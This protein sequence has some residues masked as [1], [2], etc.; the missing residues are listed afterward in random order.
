MVSVIIPNYNHAIFLQ[1]RIESILHQTYQNFEIII[2]DDCSTDNSREVIE[3]FRSDPKVSHIVLNKENSGTTFK[4]WEKG[5][6]LAK[7][8]WIWIAESDD[9][10]ERTLLEELVSKSIKDSNIV[11]SY[12]QSVIISPENRILGRTL[13]DCLYETIDGEEYVKKRMFGM[14]S[15]VN[16]SMAIFK[17]DIWNKIPKDFVK[18]KYC[19]DWLFWVN[20]CLQGKVYISGKY[21]NYYLRHNN[22]VGSK[23]I[24]TGLD[25]LEG[26]LIYHY[27]INKLIVN[28]DEKKQALEA[29]AK[30]YMNVKYDLVN[31]EIQK[32]VLESMLNLDPSM[33]YI[34]KQ[35][36]FILKRHK[37]VEKV[38][39]FIK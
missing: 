38:K 11:L 29:R 4:Q 25:F 2:L 17:K 18:M 36:E 9:W 3:Q 7:G 12:C 19:G 34:I 20:V 24:R 5:I 37:F 16:A 6:Q 13:T 22:N 8:D 32:Q 31:S 30:L 15:I 39:L 27:V 26:N 1:Q 28:L 10:C 21:L 14:N 33:K 35:H 23:A